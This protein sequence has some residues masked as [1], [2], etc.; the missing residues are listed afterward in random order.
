MQIRNF[1]TDDA[2]A[3]SDVVCRTLRVTNGPDYPAEVIEEVCEEY[4]PENLRERSQ[5]CDLMVAEDDGRV[6]GCAGLDGDWVWGVFVDPDCQGRGVGR[7]L[8]DAIER[9]ARNRRVRMLGLHSSTTAADFYRRLG[10]RPVREIL[11]DG[12]VH[13]IVMSRHV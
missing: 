13:Q 4:S 10:W 11:R 6:V 2:A 9:I 7:L 12:R 8:M 3:V 5:R 1:S